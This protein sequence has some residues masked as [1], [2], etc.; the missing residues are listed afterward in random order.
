MTVG[1][2]TTGTWN[3][4]SFW[5]PGTKIWF[6]SGAGGSMSWICS[7]TSVMNSESWCGKIS[8]S[9]AARSVSCFIGYEQLEADSVRVSGI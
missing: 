3:G 5:L 4:F 1:L 9:H 8:C 6:V 2:L 7:M